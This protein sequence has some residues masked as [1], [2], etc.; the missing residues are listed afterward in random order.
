MLSADKLKK[1]CKTRQMAAGQLAEHLTAGGRSSAQA[2]AAVKNWQRGFYKPE[3]SGDDIRALASALSVNENDLVEWRSFCKYAPMSAR[4]ARLVTKMISG[5]GVQDALDL[6]KFTH[7]RA[8]SVVN[9]VLKTA[10]ADADE[11][12]AD[13][14]NLYV[15]TARVDDAGVR[16]GTKRWIAKDRGRAHSIRK[17]ACHIHITVAQ[18]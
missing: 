15:S 17:K 7:Q 2:K 3:P 11:Q 5:R 10:V 14:E 8:A 12:Q 16:I 13:V 9:N 1:V 6:L 4:K 18:I